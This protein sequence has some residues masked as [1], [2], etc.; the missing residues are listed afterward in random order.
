MQHCM[1][2]L[3]VALVF[4]WYIKQPDNVQLLITIS[5][6]QSD[7]TK[8][9]PHSKLIKSKG[10]ITEMKHLEFHKGFVLYFEENIT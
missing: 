7:C 1:F 6:V 5:L 9:L 3:V 2:V 4:S 10:D 8:C